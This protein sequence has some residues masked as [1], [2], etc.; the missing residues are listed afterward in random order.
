[1]QTE[2]QRGIVFI[3]K[4][5]TVE[6]GMALGGTP[7]ALR[8]ETAADSDMEMVGRVK[9]GDIAAFDMLTKK[10]R[11]RLYSVIYNMVSNRE[12]AMDLTQD[13]FIKAF[14]NI[15][16]F[17]GCSAFYTW[18][19]RIAVNISITFLKRNRLRRFFS[20][21]K[22]DEELSGA[23]MLEKL[24]ETRPGARKSALLGELREK[25]NEALQN[26]SIEHRTVVV[27]FE[28]EGLSHAQIAE[29]TGSREATV[30]SRLH[31]AKRQLQGML[32]DY[33]D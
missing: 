11:E 27:L 14:S 10:Y 17:R 23:E 19:Y 8:E 29:I 13:A 20:F 33:L 9:N 16:S 1:M 24:S 5:E 28:I 22:I 3:Y 32:K 2:I 31:Y 18:L 6:T 12:D 4:M 26:L 21:E 7:S 30:R 25:L 15:N